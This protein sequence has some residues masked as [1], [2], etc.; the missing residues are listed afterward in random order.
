MPN[1]L[2]SLVKTLEPP[3]SLSVNLSYLVVGVDQRSDLRRRR[4]L[5]GRHGVRVRVEREGDRR[6]PEALRDDLRMDARFE[7]ERRVGSRRKCRQK[8]KDLLPD[9]AR[10]LGLALA[11]DFCP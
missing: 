3:S 2:R 6:V 4:F 8:R 1:W 9:P 7:G 10:A 5:Q 11:Q